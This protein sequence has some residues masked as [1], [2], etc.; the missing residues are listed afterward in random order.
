MTACSS[1]VDIPIF[2]FIR[3]TTTPMTDQTLRRGNTRDIRI[4]GYFT[5][6]EARESTGNPRGVRTAKIRKFTWILAITAIPGFTSDGA[7]GPPCVSPRSPCDS[8]TVAP[9]R[10]RD[11]LAIRIPP[12][13]RSPR[14]ASPAFA[15]TRARESVSFLSSRSLS[16]RRTPAENPPRNCAKLAARAPTRSLARKIRIRTRAPPRREVGGV[17]ALSHSNPAATDGKFAEARAIS[18][19]ANNTSFSLS[20]SFPF[21]RIARG[22]FPRWSGMS[23][24]S[25]CRQTRSVLR[26]A[27]T[28][29]RQ[30]LETSAERASFLSL[31]VRSPTSVHC[32]SSPS[33]EARPI[34]ARGGL[35]RL[36]PGAACISLRSDRES[37][38]ILRGARARANTYGAPRDVKA[39]ALPYRTMLAPRTSTTHWRARLDWLSP[40]A[41]R[42][43]PP[44]ASRRFGRPRSRLG[45][46]RPRCAGRP[47]GRRDGACLNTNGDKRTRE[48][49]SPSYK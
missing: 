22:T 46:P 36:C 5:D 18:P 40:P 13:S 14:H 47:A 11:G 8:R 28:W 48:N 4:S 30:T 42:N 25:V 19:A 10:T 6:G 31:A 15:E 17:P 29:E 3:R 7:S 44:V 45:R 9:S 20:L 41:A 21:R 1:L 32:L 23:A 49:E 35:Q 26:S 43:E 16:L 24:R 2:A 38:E 37:D 27:F 34:F 12:G 33:R 39:A